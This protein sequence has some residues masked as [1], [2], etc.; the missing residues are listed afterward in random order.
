MK[1][2]GYYPAPFVQ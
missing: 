2:F 1:I